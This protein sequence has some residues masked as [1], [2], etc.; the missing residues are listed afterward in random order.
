MQ[1]TLDLND[2]T[3][4]RLT[5]PGPML[6]TVLAAWMLQARPPEAVHRN[7]IN[8]RKSVAPKVSQV[9]EV[10]RLLELQR[11]PYTLIDLCL[12][13]VGAV[14]WQEG[15]ERVSALGPDYYRLELAMIAEATK[16]IAALGL[17]THQIPRWTEQLAEQDGRPR[18]RL[19]VG[20]QRLHAVGLI[21][22]SAAD[23]ATAL[24]FIDRRLR[25]LASGGINQMMDNLH[26]RIRWHPPVISV[27]EPGAPTDIPSPAGG[28]GLIIAPSVFATQVHYFFDGAAASPS[29]LVVPLQDTSQSPVAGHHQLGELLGRKRAAILLQLATRATCTSDLAGRC[30]ITAGAVSEHTR[31][32]RESGLITTDRGRQSI[33]T[34]TPAGAALIRAHL[35]E[36]AASTPINWPTTMRKGA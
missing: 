35:T 2:L 28:R 25:D 16:A 30:A 6:E 20:L 32:L 21:D 24:A 8:W 1:I 14:D 27:D 3:N 7:H 12:P 15:V 9:S 11:P 23:T 10:R 22:R 34:I 18:E 19:I 29:L 13:T 5:A 33:H 17:P 36:A 26:P 4:I 31:I